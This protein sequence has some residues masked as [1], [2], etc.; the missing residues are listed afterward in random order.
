MK[1]ALIIQKDN[2]GIGGIETNV[3]YDIKALHK[4]SYDVDFYWFTTDPSLL[5][6]AFKPIFEE[7]KVKIVKTHKRFIWFRFDCDDI[8]NYDKVIIITYGLYDYLRDEKIKHFFEKKSNEIVSCLFIPH[9]KLRDCFLE[10]EYRGFMRKIALKYSEQIYNF[11]LENGSLYFFA[12][13]HLSTVKEK[14]NL[15]IVDNSKYLV[16]NTWEIPDFNEKLIRKKYHKDCFKIYTITRFDFP[17]KGYL[18]GLIDTFAELLSEYPN[19]TLNIVG[20]GEDEKI[21]IKKINEKDEKVREAIKLIGKVSPLDLPKLFE[22]ADVNVGVAG[23]ILQGAINGV[24]SLP[25]R[26]YSYKCETYGFLSNSISKTVSD[27]PGESIYN[28]LKEIIEFD[29][30]QYVDMAY[31]S[32]K[33]GKNLLYED[34]GIKYLLDLKNKKNTFFRK[35]WSIY[36]IFTSYYTRVIG[37]IKKIFKMNTRNDFLE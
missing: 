8:P 1:Y 11:L 32:Y 19:M 2:M 20:Y 10:Y 28:Y 31:E 15:S 25:V 18:L 14:Y 29:E 34:D 37:L 6:P 30:D 27:E 26:H 35:R 4:S 5:D 33:E 13:K 22:D 36:I 17:H 21:L 9:F 16:K 7:A 3:A 23:A 24:I 12:E